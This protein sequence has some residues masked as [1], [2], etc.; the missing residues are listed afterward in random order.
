M[1]A[2]IITN[3]TPNQLAIAK[4]NGRPIQLDGSIAYYYDGKLYMER[5]D[6]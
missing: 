5:E 3:Y 4:S 2:E 6:G 1:K